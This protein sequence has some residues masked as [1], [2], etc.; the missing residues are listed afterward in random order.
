MRLVAF[1]SGLST[2]I[3]TLKDRVKTKRFEQTSSTKLELQTLLWSLNELINLA[4]NSNITLTIYTDSQN[5]IGLPDRSSVV[6][7]RNYLSSKNK[8]LNNY[9]QY[10]EFYH[11]TSSVKCKLVKVVGHQASSKKDNIDRLFGLVDIPVSFEAAA[12]LAAL[13]HP[14]HLVRLSSWG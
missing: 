12:L 2:T 7:Q 4:D 11:L 13:T 8:R 3:D 9:Q 10:Q 1:L 6:E 5:I 14:N